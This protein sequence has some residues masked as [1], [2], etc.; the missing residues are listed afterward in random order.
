MCA[1]IVLVVVVIVASGAARAPPANMLQLTVW[2]TTRLDS[3]VAFER[4]RPPP[5]DS[6]ARRKLCG[7]EQ[8]RL[9]RNTDSSGSRSSSNNEYTYKNLK[10]SSS[11]SSSNKYNNFYSNLDRRG[12]E[13]SP[14]ASATATFRSLEKRSRATECCYEVIHSQAAF[15]TNRSFRRQ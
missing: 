13:L 4:K 5:G 3:S 11:S 12:P 10:N 9:R 14:S 7:K 2:S 8:I 1:V 15:R 6:T